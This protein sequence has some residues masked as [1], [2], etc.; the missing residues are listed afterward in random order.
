M[1]IKTLI[2]P[3]CLQGAIALFF[4][5]ISVFGATAQTIS[6]VVTDVHDG[7]G[8]PGV[9][10]L[11]KG[12]TIG[13]VSDLDGNYTLDV[14]DGKIIQ[15]SMVGY[16]TAEVAVK[17]QL[18]IDVQ[19][20]E[21]NKALDEVVVTALG[22]KRDKK[23][24]GYSMTEL[25][26][27]QLTETRDPNVVNSLSGKVAGLQVKQ[28]GTGP[29]GSS[30]IVIRGNNSIGSNNQPLIV[31]DGVP[32]DN[33]SGGTD[34]FWGN[35]NVDKGSGISDISPD[36]IESM[37][38]LKG[39]AAAALYG[40]RAGNGVVMITTKKGSQREGLGISVNSNLTFDNPMETPEMQNMYGQGSNGAFDRTQF[41]SW[42]AQ[43]DGSIVENGL[44]SHAYAARDNNFYKDFMQTGTTWTNSIDMSSGGEN[45]T[46]RASATRLDNKGVIPGNNFDRTSINLRSTGNF[47]KYITSDMKVTYVN[48]H[49]KNR[50][51]LA[52]DPDNLFLNNLQTP[53]SV[54]FS[55][56]SAF[57]STGW[58]RPDGKPAAYIDT[59]NATPN[60]PYWSTSKNTN[61]DKKDRFI[62]LASIKIQF[63]D[64]LDL[65][66]RSGMDLYTVQYENIHATGTP[67]WQATGD[68]SVIN[69]KFT[70]NNS[71]FL[72]TAK[73]N[74]N[75]FGIVGALGGNIMYR[76]STWQRAEANGLAIP[77]FYTITNGLSRKGDYT[78]TRKQINSIYGTASMSWD[79]FLYLDLTARNDWSSTLPKENSS[80]FYPSVG[81]SWVFTQMLQQMDVNT[82]I[83]S[84]GK[85]R[86]SWAQVGN[87][88]DA[89]M[90]RDYMNIDYKNG[91]LEV[92][93]AD[94]IA[95]PNLKSETINSWEVGLDLKA[96][97]NRLGFDFAYYKKNARDQILKIAVPAA[98]GYKQKMVNA[99]NVENS[100]FEIALNGTPVQTSSGF[101]WDTQLNWAKNDN[102][103]IELTGDTKEQ[104]L[105]DPSV[106][107]LRVVAR[108]GGSYGDIYGYGYQRND[109][110]QVIIGETGVPLRTDDMVKLGN[111]QPSWMAGWS[112]TFSY[113][114][115]TVNAMIDMRYGGDVYMGS[116][117]A[118]NASGTLANTLNGREG[119]LVIPG[120]LADGSAN[121]KQISSQEY[122]TGVSGITEEFMYD[123]T[124]IRLRELSIGY[125]LPKKWLANTPFTRVKASF[126][127]R[128]LF[129]IY[130][131]TKGFDP[132]AA[133]TT[134]NAQGIEY[135]SMPTMRSL[136]FNLNVAF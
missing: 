122:W 31:V 8:L 64:W 108:E 22:I 136:G 13:T 73:G 33:F 77:E 32:I 10:I 49:S 21:D 28:S 97:N 63:T 53:R 60:N 76:A 119:D 20:K 6:G 35:K 107:F 39:P 15:Y 86:L 3:R 121:S 46:F 2:G 127:G 47:G 82:G 24:L 89:Y 115:I 101:T 55:D 100:G 43:M 99:G 19:L 59:H 69:E 87:D 44:G 84:F 123:A 54:G 45:A 111:F 25:K 128:N 88:T 30:R 133:Y 38:V 105:S 116:I 26:G 129:M 110:G 98:S 79:N 17:N 80:Y 131:N 4:S 83:L 61:K 52:A 16:V 125:S 112:N 91:A 5:F 104:I 114:N 117:K 62:G 134:G 81:G 124:N 85:V 70:E 57:E 27:D 74:W 102:K 126:V 48:Q 37:S 96:F 130:S 71:D 118:G 66:L 56:Y 67:Y 41:N 58:A 120:V 18:K 12:T 50:I 92:S 9:S 93:S 14:Q 11:V 7:Y 103:I 135:G 68:Y 51:K 78:K 72:F 75:K 94:W 95:N 65:N 36:D 1:R 34:D 132:E 109:A 23:A 90:L 40:S 42:G 113:K 29:A 106:T